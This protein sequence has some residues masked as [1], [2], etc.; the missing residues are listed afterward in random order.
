MSAKILPNISDALRLIRSGRLNEATALLR[1]GGG[2][3]PSVQVNVPPAQV[4]D[5]QSLK[6]HLP[7]GLQ[8]LFKGRM[9]AEP[10]V[11]VPDGATFVER[12][13]ANPFGSRTYKLYVPASARGGSLPLVVMLHG[14]TQNPDDFAAGTRMN[15]LAEERGF[16]VAYPAQPKSAN[17]NGCWNWFERA[18]LAAEQG[19]PSLI[20]GIVRQIMRDQPVDPD[21][22][23][24]GG[25]SAGGAA[26]LNLASLHPELFAAVGVHSGLAYGAAQDMPSAFAAMR[27]GAASFPPRTGRVVPTIVFHGSQDGTV[28]PRN[29]VQIIEQ[30]S[31]GQHYARVGEKDQVDGGHDYS[32]ASYADPRGRV[33]LEQWTVHG[34][35]HAWFGGSSTGSYTDPRGPDASREMIRFFLDHHRTAQ[36]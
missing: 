1:Q 7:S 33:M 32:R 5:L 6:Q 12:S 8:G 2:P 34:A 31:A 13:F 30:A 3:A 10:A 23:Y 18:H 16:L 27:Q 22:V 26:A 15:A 9:P 36:G 11:A 19:E 17:P 21:R 4:F 24:I 35:G 25:L 20:V 29:A 28:H 14:C